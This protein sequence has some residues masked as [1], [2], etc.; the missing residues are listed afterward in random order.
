MQHSCVAQAQ[1]K[2]MHATIDKQGGMGK[3]LTYF[4]VSLA[5]LPSLVVLAMP[6]TCPSPRWKTVISVVG[7]DRPHAQ[8]SANSEK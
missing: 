2:G 6:S 5:T 4:S 7:R 3:G 8:A 1:N